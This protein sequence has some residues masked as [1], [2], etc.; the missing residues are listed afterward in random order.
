MEGMTGGLMRE[1][2]DLRFKVLHPILEPFLAVHGYSRRL[3]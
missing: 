3:R 2:I 1:A